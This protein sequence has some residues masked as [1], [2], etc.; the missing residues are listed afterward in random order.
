MFASSGEVTY[1]GAKPQLTGG[2]VI[3]DR[4]G[5]RGLVLVAE[6]LGVRRVEMFATGNIVD[7]GVFSLASGLQ[8][9]T[10]AVGVTP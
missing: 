6:N 3:I 8:N 4:G 1:Q 10:G 9:T 2:A 7:R 5:L